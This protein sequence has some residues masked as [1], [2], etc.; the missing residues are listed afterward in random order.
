MPHDDRP[1]RVGRPRAVPNS[2]SEL[3]PRD[4]ILDAA[5]ALFVE[6]GFSATS[7]RSIAERV[8][9][10]QA[11]LYYHFAGKDDVL[12]ELLTTSVRPSLEVVRGVEQLV[13]DSASAAGALAALVTADVETLVR[14]PHNVG[15]LYLLPEVQG[16]RYD[17]FRVERRA[18][19]DTYGRLGAAAATPDVGTTVTADRL[20]ALLIQLA[21]T[22]IQIRREGDVDDADRDAIVATCLRVCGLDAPAIA[23]A[24]QEA[25]ALLASVTV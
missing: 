17:E 8:G 10:R 4:Q 12:V 3:S 21:E 11:S 19:Q 5:A 6:N 16:E 22:V 15:T 24:L 1:S 14:T 13:P 25:D 23:S 7:T 18:L 9:I 2:S 20:G